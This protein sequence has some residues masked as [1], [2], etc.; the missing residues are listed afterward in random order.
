MS[1]A[2]PQSQRAALSPAAAPAL[3]FSIAAGDVSLDPP[4]ERVEAEPRAADDLHH[5]GDDHHHAED[6]IRIASDRC[7]T[8]MRMTSAAPTRT[9]TTCAAPKRKETINASPSRGD[10]IHET[11]RQSNSEIRS[12]IGY[13][14]VSTAEQATEGVSIDAQSAR[15]QAWAAANGYRLAALHVDAGLS[16]KR[17]DNRPELQHALDEAC[18]QKAA[19]VV[20]SLSRLARSTRDTLA[21]AERLDRAGADLVSLSEKIDTTSAAGRMIFRLLAV[22]AEFERDLASERTATALAHKR[23]RGEK[24]GGRIPFGYTLAGDGVNLVP[25]VS[26]QETIAL[27]RTLR[28]EGKTF[29]AIARELQARGVATKSGGATWN[30]KT[31]RAICERRA[32]QI[33]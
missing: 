6:E 5:A 20:Y 11:A 1:R 18:R 14:R 9:P 15:I 23:Q 31:I 4:R 3:L 33:G 8:R 21:M 25:D 28:D 27:I 19:L 2:R 7:S 22:L 29:R 16:G 32:A 17:A 10:A 13:V 24:T 30:P 12:A 26:E